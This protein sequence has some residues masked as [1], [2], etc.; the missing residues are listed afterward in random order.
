LLVGT[1]GPIRF[2]R[3]RG[4]TD[5]ILPVMIYVLVFPLHFSRRVRWGSGHVVRFDDQT[6]NIIQALVRCD[7]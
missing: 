3:Q 7:A 5:E 4:I 2:F 6:Q 1:F